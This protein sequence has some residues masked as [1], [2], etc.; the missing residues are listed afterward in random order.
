MVAMMING[1]IGAGIFGLPSKVHALAGPSGLLAFA[2]CAVIVGAIALCFAEVSSRFTGTGGPYLYA[3]EAFGDLAGFLVGWVTWIARVTAQATISNVMA[4]YFA[5][6]WAPAGTGWGRAAAMIAVTGVLTVI[7]LIGVRQAAGSI[8][9]LTIGKLAPL[10]LFVGVG[11]FFV[12]PERF[13]GVGAIEAG[14]FTQAMLQLVFAF[15][16]FEAVVVAAG[17]ARDPRRDLPFALLVALATATVLY[18]LIQVVCVGTLPGLAASERP[19]ADASARFAGAAGGSVI[20]LGAL[21]STIGVLCG[22]VLVAPR[23][24]FAMSERGQLPTAFGFVHPRFHTPA[25][26]ILTTSA[27]GLALSISGTFAYLVNVNV[28]ARLLTYAGTAGALIV[29]RRRER[30]R[31]ALFSAPA[32]GVVASLCLAACVW[33]LVASGVRGLRD[34]GLAIAVGL[35]LYATNRWRRHQKPAP[36]N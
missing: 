4:S 1:I 27:V 3:Q 12:E 25:V 20:T 5:F 2:A 33:L 22:I 30:E 32:G 9:A 18:V 34:V 14:S 8:G 23:I 35:L 24:L 36:M 17:E 29:F 6:F 13:T 11:L 31:P 15:A 16:G 21:V 28:I 10:V 19:L 7:N 26:A